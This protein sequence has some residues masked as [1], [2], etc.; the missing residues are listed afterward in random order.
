[1]SEYHG[2]LSRFTVLDLTR[3]RSGP[4]CVRQLADWGANVIKIEAPEAIDAAKGMGGARSG[5]DFQNLH[6][7]K[8]GITLNMKDPKG[9]ALFMKMVATADVVV[10][11]FRPD[12]KNRLG[13]D[14][15]SLKAVNKAIVLGSISGFGQD[16]PYENRPGFDQ[17]AQG[18]GGLMSITGLP[19]QGPVRVGIP[20]ADLTAGIY[21]ALGIL[22]ALLERDE[23]GEG[24]W[25]QSSLL[26]SQIA[27][28]DFQAA[29]WLVNKEVAPQA[30]N[31]H[32]T[33]IPTGVFKTADGHINIA[34]AGDAMWD[35]LCDVLGAP[36]MHDN[37]DFSTG[38]SRSSNRNAVNSAIESYTLKKTSSEW[39]EVLA[40]A[41]VPCGP[42]YSIDQMFAD[43]QVR[44]LAMEHPVDHPTQGKINLVGQAIAL[45][46]H[47]SRKGVPTPE[48]GQHTNEVLENL[49]LSPSDIN[50]LRSGGVI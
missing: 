35:R 41:G 12:V 39:I 25:V 47:T 48:R 37:P 36:E 16:G 4:T 9:L 15:E 13:I 34:A 46:R 23:T 20:I 29:R 30:G 40:K 31:N 28:L 14:Y 19:G 50:E 45:S 17:I 26:Q 7:N 44:H 32:P 3:V 18:M 2:P 49:G 21:C 38:E 22:I 8:R 6:R 24:Q 10:E 1:M 11:N 42:I 33:S 27:M 5:S 43:P